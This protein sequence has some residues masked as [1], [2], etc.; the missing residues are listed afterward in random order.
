MCSTLIPYF[1]EPE[2]LNNTP[3]AGALQTSLSIV[4]DERQAAASPL[5]V[6]LSHIHKRHIGVD[7]QLA[8][9]AGSRVKPTTDAT[10]GE[11]ASSKQTHTFATPIS[12]GLQ[13]WSSATA[14]GNRPAK[15]SH[16][17][18]HNNKDKESV[19][20]VE[21][22][23]RSSNSSTNRHNTKL[24][25]QK[26]KPHSTDGICSSCDAAAV[27]ATSPLRRCVAINAFA[28]NSQLH[29][30][31]R[32]TIIKLLTLMTRRSRRKSETLRRR[33]RPCLSVCQTVEENCPYMLPSDR[34]PAM[35]T[36]YAGEPTFLCSGACSLCGSVLGRILTF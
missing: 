26:Q 16:V 20:D 1:A 17:H 10:T 22:T 32:I 21:S 11:S 33:I 9:I 30:T 34:A 15:R 19:V 23:V 5:I 36:Q 6:A 27:A 25:R 18:D 24:P 4:N 29:D 31:N 3:K 13:L 2:D 7:K 12:T 35:P 8:S 28:H 14:D